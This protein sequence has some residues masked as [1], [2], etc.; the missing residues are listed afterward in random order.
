MRARLALRLRQRCELALMPKR[1]NRVPGSEPLQTPGATAVADSSRIAQWV[2]LGVLTL[3]VCFA[4]VWMSLQHGRAVAVEG[5]AIPASLTRS[6]LTRFRTDAWQLP[7]EPLLGFVEIPGGSFLM[8]SDP[9]IDP[10]AYENERWS[11][12]RKQGTVGLPVYYIGRYEVTV[13]QL[14]AFAAAARY[15]LDPAALQAAPDHP[16]THVS[17]TDALAYA[18]WLQTA[19][20][21]WP[22]APPQ[23]RE[24][25]RSGWLITLPSEAQWEKAARTSDGRIYPWGNTPDASQGNFGTSGTRRVGSFACAA[26][27]FGLADLSG[28]VW[29]LTRSPF[30]PYPYDASDRAAQPDAPALFVMRGGSFSDAS[31]NVRAATRGGVDPGARRAFIGFRLVLMQTVGDQ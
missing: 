13:A 5:L 25:L 31:N 27:A 1:S 20:Q 30:Q 7:D 15:R 18:R 23:L 16:A 21:T 6:N 29:E 11:M 9:A 28:N 22:D 17:W 19:L 12:Q 26:C 10:M 3:L 2:G 24:L 8:G 4:A 14:A